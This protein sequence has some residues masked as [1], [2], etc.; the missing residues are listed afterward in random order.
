MCP[1]LQP[2]GLWPARL[3]CPQGS[4]G[5][6]TGVGCHALL[7]GIFLTLGLNLCLLCLLHWQVGSLPLKVP[8]KP[9]IAYIYIH[10]NMRWL[11]G[12]NDSVD[13]SVRKLQELLM[14]REAW[15]AAGHGVTKSFTRL[16][17]GTELN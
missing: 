4:P 16:I 13:M 2:H 11:D 5:K 14:D 17:D 7:Q 10:I 1:T 3:R 15:R 6:K 8:G 9:P 12:N